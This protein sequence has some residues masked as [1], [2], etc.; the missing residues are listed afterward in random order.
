MSYKNP[1]PKRRSRLSTSVRLGVA[2]VAACFIAGPV[3]SNPLNPTVV[4]GTAT[5][6]QAGNVLTVTNSN[7]AIID[8]QKF[9]INAG[10]TTH[11]AQ[12]AASSTVLNRV[13]NDPTAIY[14]TLS[15]NGR[16]WL[17]NPAGIMVGPGG[18]IDTAGFVASTLSVRNEDF[19][20]GRHLFVNDGSAQNVIN[21]GEITTP[22]GGSVYLIGSNVSN[23]GIITTPGGETILAAGA[24]VSLIDSATPGVKVDITGAAGNA[25]NLGQITA[26]AGR[27]GIAGVI[28]KNS[29]TLNAS[30]VVNEGGRIFLKASQDAYVDGNGRIV[31]TGTKGGSVAVLGKNVTVTDNAEIDAS[32]ASGGGKILVGGDYQGKNPEIQNASTSYFGPAARLTADATEVGAGGTVIVWADDTTQAYGSISARGGALGGAGGL[33]E[34]SGKRLLDVIG[35]KV[36]TR[37]VDGSAG[38]WLLDPAD[39]SI[40]HSTSTTASNFAPTGASSSISDFDINSALGTTN[41]TITTSAGSGGAGVITIYGG[42]ANG[43]TG[44]A[45]AIV[46]NTSGA[47]R[48][49]VLAA[50]AGIDMQYGAKILGGANSPLNVTFKG[51]SG[52]NVGGL[53]STRGGYVA[54]AGQGVSLSNNTYGSGVINATTDALPGSSTAVDS[55]YGGRV[56]IDAGA[57]MFSMAYGAFIGTTNQSRIVDA[58]GN[59][60]GLVA[61]GISAG[62]VSI[63][64][65]ATI[66]LNY[67]TS[68]SGFGGGDLG[69]IPTGAG[70]IGLGNYGGGAFTLN[71]TELSRLIMPSAGADNCGTGKEGC[72][73]WIGNTF[74]INDPLDALVGDIPIT[75]SNFIA[76]GADFTLNGGN[77]AP[78]RV[79]LSTTGTIDD[80]GGLGLKAGHLALNGGAGIGNANDGFDY[81]GGSLLLTSEFGNVVA[82]SVGIADLALRRATAPNG[83]VTVNA[84][85][86]VFLL[87][88]FSGQ[89]EIAGGSITLHAAGNISFAEYGGSY[90]VN[91]PYGPFTDIAAS[92]STIRA[93]GTLALQSDNGFISIVGD[94]AAYGGMSVN[95]YGGISVTD[96]GLATMG[97]MSL[98]SYGDIVLTGINRGVIVKSNGDMSINAANVRAYGGNT[99]NAIGTLAFYGSTAQQDLSNFGAGV[100]LATNGAQTITA[101]GEILLQAGSANNTTHSGSTMYGASVAI[102]SGGAQDISAGA[103]KVYAGSSGHDNSAEIQ[104]TGNQSLSIYGGGLDIRGGGDAST[105]VY[106][107][108]G[109][110]N[111][112]ARIQHGQSS[113]GGDV[114]TGSGNQTLTLHGGASVILQ[115]GSGTGVLGYYGSDCALVLGA[116]ACSG[117]SNDAHIQN[118]IGAQTLDFVSGGAISITGG[119]AG[120]QNWAGISNQSTATTQLI[121]GNPNITLTGGSGGGTGVGYGGDVFQLSN[122]AGINSDGT[123]AQT[124]YAGTITINGGSAAYGGAGFGSDSGNGL[125]ITTTGDLSMYGGSSSAGDPFAAATYIGNKAGGAINLNVGGNLYV[126][127]GSGTAA[128]V[129]IGSIDGAANVYINTGSNVSVVADGSHVG[130]GSQS[131]TYGASVTIYAGGNLT[132]VDSATRGVMIGSL[133]DSASTTDVTLL[134]GGDISIGSAT[135]YGALIGVKNSTGS[136]YVDILAGANGVYGGNLLLDGS[137]NISSGLGGVYLR[138]E[139]TTATN[140]NVTQN[141][142]STIYGSNVAIEAGGNLNLNGGIFASAGIYAAAGIDTGYRFG[143]SYNASRYGG[144]VSIGGTLQAIGDMELY[145]LSGSNG[146]TRGSIVQ[147]SGSI[148]SAN[149]MTIGAWG[150]VDLSG[151][152]SAIGTLSATAGAAIDCGDGCYS[153]SYASP[154]GGNLFVRSGA[155]LSSSYKVELA[156]NV[157]YGTYANGNITQSSGSSI[158]GNNVY[159]N[160]GGS[161]GIGGTASA[162]SGSLSVRAGYQSDY[163]GDVAYGVT[164]D[165]GNILVSGALSGAY[166]VSLTANSGS[167]FGLNG[168]ITQ[169]AGSISVTNGGIYIN[170]GGDVIQS[171]GSISTAAGSINVAGGGN[172]TLNGSAS[173][174]GG[175]GGVSSGFNNFANDGGNVSLGGDVFA[176]N[177]VSIYA[178]TGAYGSGVSGNI[179]QQGGSITSANS[180]NLFAD[181]NIDIQGRVETPSAVYVYAGLDN[182][183]WS[184]YP[185]HTSLYGGDISLGAGS[186]LSASHLELVANGGTAGGSLGNIRQE[187][188]GLLHATGVTSLYAYAA[189]NVDLLGATLVDA[190]AQVTINAGYDYPG[191]GGQVFADK[192]VSIAGL[193]AEGSSVSIYATGAIRATTQGAASIYANISNSSSGG[194]E[195]A[196]TGSAEPTFINLDDGATANSS[197]TFTHSGSDLT[198][199]SARSFTTY[200]GAGAINVSA[201]SGNLNYLGGALSGGSVILSAN[202]QLNIDG[203]LSA[204]GALGLAAGGTLNVSNFVGAHSVSLSGPTINLVNGSVCAVN[205]AIAIGSVINIGAGYG[206]LAGANVLLRG[207]TEGTG[208]LNLYGGV[209]ATGGNLEFNLGSI[210]AY[211]GGLFAPV[212]I[213]GLVTGDILLGGGAYIHAGNDVWLTQNGV[214]SLLSMSNGGHVLAGMPTTIHLDFPNRDSSGVVTDGSPGSGLFVVVNGVVTPATAGNG[215]ELTLRPVQTAVDPCVANPD[216][217]KPPEPKETPI[218]TALPPPELAKTDPT[219]PLLDPNATTGGTEGNFGDTGTTGGTTGDQPT[220][221]TKTEEGTT[222]SAA[223]DQ[224]SKDEKKDE[225][226]EKDKKDKK[227]DEA[228]DEKKDEKPAQKKV[229]QCT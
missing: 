91:G 28:V 121:F 141:A 116:A 62:D 30:S 27:I 61:V 14:G 196:N 161:V 222:T 191:Y 33:V 49:L 113:Y 142:H 137:S 70:V 92:T 225:K 176:S 184:G 99:V 207:A 179:V 58:A 107:G 178:T 98:T 138:A 185:N 111:N 59:P 200:G 65:N 213:I 189:G 209:Q 23:E 105:S 152:V 77:T 195:I 57:G 122:D 190:G 194:I 15:S 53:I 60:T 102:Q 210:N 47:A 4:N 163:F 228:K 8:W 68:G 226:D 229:A 181:G 48:S 144:D 167:S 83:S 120:R 2:A 82:N 143:Y 182:A 88:Y 188:G 130:I 208:T 160:A 202:N 16:V 63:D 177:G 89:S 204:S 224:G 64:P 126:K 54:I 136:G 32:G 180:I 11:F 19:L 13:L 44:S 80:A 216:L 192:H 17:V 220:T 22:A 39:I 87:P 149:S 211:G 52:V 72:R 79:Q 9:S 171:A 154:S 74:V 183:A 29:G 174:Y 76:D 110:Y 18:R 205:D 166:G 199:D 132:V 151:A 43:G 187:A 24:T 139:Q 78:K 34:T 31:T 5:F 119:S 101:S 1:S 114:Y 7:G 215:L 55:A 50:D 46:Q 186:Q 165:G 157:G 69:F 123:G 125:F 56:L 25:T 150:N 95:A 146:G 71:N 86:N 148:V 219:Q 21:Q 10:E 201:L 170:G 158:V 134:A 97:T 3:L 147:Q 85:G 198:L 51:N 66:K 117:S 26:E 103:I 42:T 168:N 155:S 100:T 35:I 156:A 40:V 203:P 153:S 41:I 93:G 108:Q 129:L 90:T 127:A 221:E 84:A 131:A 227:S 112:A 162:S 38:M 75:T 81:Y 94:H 104:A 73:T 124:V 67:A 193:D 212:D 159:V 214:T 223:K 6:S 20:A 133:S 12:T 45:P 217:C 140:G 135:G 169:S 96:G 172:V 115:A 109:S 206:R 218:E 36:D 37:A 173:A 128:P 106:G 197:V 164:P 145:A 175:S 118:G